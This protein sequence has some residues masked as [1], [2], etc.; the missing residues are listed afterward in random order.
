MQK[1]VWQNANGVELDLTSGNYGIT[2]WEGFSNA[3][4]NIQSQQVP[5][6]DGGVFLD[7]LI[8]Q[9]ELSVTLAMQDNN[10]LELRYQQRREL[11][12]AL[13]PK[14][15]EGYLIYTNDYTSKRIKCVAQIPL[16]ETH[17]SN[18]AGTPRASLSWTA[19]EPYWEDLEDTE[20]N[21]N[22]GTL[23]RI[24]N[25]GD[26]ET[27]VK[28]ECFSGGVVNPTIE[29]ITTGKRI[30]YKAELEGGLLIDTNI[31]EKK[32]IKEDFEFEITEQIVS[33]RD[34]CAFKKAL[35]YERVGLYGTLD[36]S[37]DGVNWKS[38]KSGTDETLYR[39]REIEELGIFIIVGAN[40]II[41]KS[42][43]GFNWE[44]VTSGTTEDLMGI[45]YSK[46]LEKI[47]VVGTNGIIIKSADG[48]NWESVTSGIEDTLT[49]IVY[50]E[51]LDLLVA[52]G[53]NRTII[54]S[55]DGES[56]TRSITT[57]SGSDFYDVTYSRKV[58]IFVAVGHNGISQTSSD[59]VTWVLRT[60]AST[61]IAK[62]VY[63]N[64][65]S[66]FIEACGTISE[67]S[68][69]R[70]SSDGV[71]WG[72]PNTNI[73]EA[74]FNAVCYSEEMN[75][76][77]VGGENGVIAI[78]N[79]GWDWVPIKKYY[80]RLELKNIAY[81]KDLDLVIAENG[82]LTAKKKGNGRWQFTTD[83][84][85]DYIT[86]I[87]E[88]KYFLKIISGNVYKSYDG[89][90]WEQITEGYSITCIIYV[91]STNT[92]VAGGR[93]RILTSSDL[94]S[95]SV[96]PLIEQSDTVSKIE[97][98]TE[99]NFYIAVTGMNTYKSTDGAS[100]E[101]VN[102]L[103]GTNFTNACYIQRYKKMFLIGYNGVYTTSDGITFTDIG[104]D[105]SQILYG[106]TFSEEMNIIIIVGTE[107]VCCISYD[108]DNWE[109]INSNVPYSLLGVVFSESQN[110]FIIVG[111]YLTILETNYLLKANLIQNISADSDMNFNLTRG[112]NTIRLT[113][114]TGNF[115]C[116]ITYRQ[117]YLGV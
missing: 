109:Q 105:T 86:Y 37:L 40:G 3:S 64:N 13:N 85:G 115:S 52:V 72:Q 8:E 11:I 70:V 38:L 75:L 71:N 92:F 69:V 90:N 36:Y 50:S 46:T 77:I 114:D 43:D 67:R 9:R 88:L 97:Y 33:I 106:I 68:V 31:G 108:G 53:H 6:Q 116:R 35:M 44:S 41:L 100:W 20:V 74:G 93:G 57:S 112:E 48:S 103:A 110:Q 29:N 101:Y 60:P 51:P 98:S 28:I 19:C 30:E 117:K 54:R 99:G 80:S 1:L 58:Q 113:R 76:C 107:G 79:N 24:E 65:L 27:Q 12:S 61:S 95:W 82:S 21:F 23:P 89:D 78:S 66:L 104:F 5:F 102:S 96:H 7:A 18:T 63:S 45:A 15:G 59:G 26:V 2:E 91:N 16:F 42:Q 87:D 39:I 10:N 34:I 22:I 81:S 84:I 94:Q 62:I 32:V 56:W 4:L 73:T 25:K 14:L 83:E 47:F 55:T 49:G 17:N 111:D